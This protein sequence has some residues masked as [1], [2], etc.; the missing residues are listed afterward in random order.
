[1]MLIG[2]QTTNPAAPTITTK[3][4]SI[5]AAAR[6][7]KI[8]WTTL[9][10]HRRLFLSLPEPRPTNFEE[11]RLV[12]RKVGRPTALP[13]AAEKIFVERLLHLSARGFPVTRQRASGALAS[14]VRKNPDLELPFHKTRGPGKNWWDRLK[15][16]HPDLVE[17][18]PARLS[19][20]RARHCTKE[21]VAQHLARLADLDEYKHIPAELI[22]NFDETQFNIDSKAS[23]RQRVF[24]QKA[25]PA[26][27]VGGRGEREEHV[28]LLACV[29][30]KGPPVPP[31]LL[32]KGERVTEWMA[33]GAPLGT[34][35]KVTENGWT[36]D[37][38]YHFYV[39][40]VLVPHVKSVRDP[41]QAAAEAASAAAGRPQPAPLNAILFVDGHASHFSERVLELLEAHRIITF[42]FPPHCTHVL[43]PLDVGVFNHLK[44]HIEKEVEALQ[45]CAAKVEISKHLVPS[46]LSKVWATVFS[47][48]HCAEAFKATALVPLGGFENLRQANRILTPKKSA[49]IPA[50]ESSSNETESEGESEEGVDGFDDE[51]A[52]PDG[53][54]EAD[55]V[56][57][58]PMSP[59]DAS[60]VASEGCEDPVPTDISDEHRP[61]AQI[62]P[63][64]Y[65]S[66]LFPLPTP[67]TPPATSLRGRLSFPRALFSPSTPTAFVGPIGPILSSLPARSS[68]AQSLSEAYSTISYQAH[69]IDLSNTKIA[70]Q[71]HTIFLLRHELEEA[72]RARYKA[73]ETILPSPPRLNATQRR[74]RGVAVEGLV[75]LKDI[76]DKRVFLQ[77]EKERKAAEKKAARAQAAEE[78]K[79]T[80][81]L[82]AED[83]KI[84]KEKEKERRAEE[85]RVEREKLAAE[86]ASAKA[87]VL[88]GRV[89]KV[90]DSANKVAVLAV[91]ASL[92]TRALFPSTVSQVESPSV[93]SSPKPAR[94][95][96]N[97]IRIPPQ[98]L[99]DDMGPLVLGETA[100]SDT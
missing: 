52:D 58:E 8:H 75:T 48:K 7:Y 88:I 78:R 28:T 73:I 94:R 56:L 5:R 95:Q 62:T 47:E 60:E 68:R 36:T 23:G 53:A 34:R 15:R 59:G 86:K 3:R 17:K 32:F 85:K 26:Q 37:D 89:T 13:A 30:A 100:A 92:V 40:D 77:E 18:R 80:K 66:L 74:Q 24:C 4:P 81:L 38:T 16:D 19:G 63:T 91:G 14:F 11:F 25:S 70:E 99:R 54:A 22:F 82:K 31:V 1:M 97:R 55:I 61:T 6:L 76:Q 50:A 90:K 87:S 71:Q 51:V 9:S 41:L 43:Q 93:P 21:V 2:P 12:Y 42:C 83:A 57:G 72:K 69:T 79:A 98:R 64:H 35:V 10:H 65:G 27:R 67:E 96:P 49:V 46:L 29:A 84:A 33:Q 44:F 20:E 39:R 45:S